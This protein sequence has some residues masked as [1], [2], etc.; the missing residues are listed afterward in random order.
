MRR[1]TPHP[2]WPSCAYDSSGNFLVTGSIGSSWRRACR[3]V[4]LW[5]ADRQ[6]GLCMV[7]LVRVPDQ[8]VE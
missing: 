7:R 5:Y 2:P 1:L 6:G 8:K 3:A 4:A